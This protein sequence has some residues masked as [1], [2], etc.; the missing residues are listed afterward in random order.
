MA[1][2]AEID[3]EGDYIVKLDVTGASV[4][5][6]AGV[7]FSALGI[8]NGEILYPGYVITIQ[9]IRINGEKYEPDAESY[10]TSDNG[11]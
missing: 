8:A 5:S 7:G 4:G 1:E 10:T 2:D 6:A 9:E 11:I 3:G